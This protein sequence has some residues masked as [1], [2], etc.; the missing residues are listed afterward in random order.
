[1][2]N[3]PNDCVDPAAVTADDHLAY[4]RGETSPAV[5]EH[6]ETC[7]GCS[8]EAAAYAGVERVLH[9]ALYR[10]SCPDSMILGEYALD[11]LDPEARTTVAQH[12][13]LCASCLRESRWFTSFLSQ[14]D[15]APKFGAVERLRRLLARPVMPEPVLSGMR[16][17]GDS[18]SV[19]YEAEGMRLTVSVQRAGRPGAGS[20][21]VGLLEQTPEPGAVATLYLDDAPVSQEA[22]DDLG[23]FLFSG[24]RAGTYRVEVTVPPSLVVVEG[25]AV[26]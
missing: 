6:M 8:R 5:A 14:P 4:A 10:R 13:V 26:A 18:D 21:L 3:L 24:V 7:P 12:L 23:N 17:A 20:I 11:L 2:T 9:A 15:E 1:M 19:T 16:G 22:V 25:I